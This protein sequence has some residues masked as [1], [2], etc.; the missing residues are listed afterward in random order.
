VVQVRDGADEILNYQGHGRITKAFGLKWF[1][2]VPWWPWWLTISQIAPLPDG[3][4]AQFGIATGKQQVLRLA[5]DD[6]SYLVLRYG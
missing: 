5:Q 1:L 6:N 3:V 4:M 2:R